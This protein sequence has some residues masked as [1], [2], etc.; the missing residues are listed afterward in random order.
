MSDRLSSWLLS[1]NERKYY[2]NFSLHWWHTVLNCVSPCQTVSHRDSC[3]ET[4]KNIFQIFYCTGD[5]LSLTVYHRV[6]PSLT[7]T[8][9][10]KRKKTEK[11]Y[12]SNFLLHR[13]H[14]VLNCVSPC[15][16]VSHRDSCQETKKNFSKIFYCTGDTPS[17]TVCHRIRLWYTFRKSAKIHRVTR[18]D[19]VWHSHSPCLTLSPVDT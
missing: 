9:V 12:F 18:F 2:S 8:P 3:Q 14:T 15:H 16:T 4:K 5:T 13:W 11:K 10:K 17:L 7:V 1:R 19:T 6:T